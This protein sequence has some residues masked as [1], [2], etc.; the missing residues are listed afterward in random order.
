MMGMRNHSQTVTV[1]LYRVLYI[2]TRIIFGGTEI[3]NNIKNCKFI[4]YYCYLI[5]IFVTEGEVYQASKVT[6]TFCI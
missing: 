3:L 5:I 2:K 1:I 6:T 4:I